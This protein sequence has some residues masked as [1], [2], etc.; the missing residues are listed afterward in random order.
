MRRSSFLQKASLFALSLTSTQFLTSCG[1]FSSIGK[2]GSQGFKKL[3]FG[4]ISTESQDTQKLVWE[5]FLADMSQEIGIPV[6]AVYSHQYVEI[7]EA[8]RFQKVQIAWYGGMSYIEAVKVAD[9][10]VFAQT[11]NSDGSPGYYSYLIMN[12]NHP[13]WRQAKLMGGDKYVLENAAKLSFAFND[14]KSTSGFLVPYYQIFAHNQVDPQNIFAD[15]TFVGNHEATALAIAENQV[16]VAT[17]NNE[18]L[19]R[20]ARNKPEIV[21]KIEVI[22]RSKLIPSDPIAYRKDLPENIKKKLQQFFYNYTNLKTLEPL[23]WSRFAPTDD[24]MWNSIRELNIARKI[25][26]V[27]SNKSLSQEQKNKKIGELNQEL[28]EIKASKK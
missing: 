7:I 18:F 3:K 14:P 21:D 28:Q 26:E 23:G 17:N 25:F 6:E 16:D 19:S 12:K 24:S 8:M 9:A 15:L 11:I 20:L 10:E 22:W 27:E 5:P 2:F 1:W 13:D 4:I